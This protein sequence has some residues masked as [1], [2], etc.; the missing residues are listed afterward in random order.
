[1]T[2]DWQRRRSA[3]NHDWLKNR[4]LTAIASFVNILDDLVEDEETERRFVIGILPQWVGRSR[5]AEMLVAD[6]DSAMSPWA[7]FRH[8]P[9]CRCGPATMGW[10]PD[11]V[12]LL[13]RRRVHVDGLCLDAR[14]SI[15]AANAAYE[16]LRN[17][18]AECADC[19][20][21]EALRSYRDRFAA[22]RSKCEEVS[23]AI[24]RFP[25]RILVV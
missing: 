10:L 22:F 18:L 9:L 24:S 16:R 4:F 12:H 1:M 13:W 8:P 5:E 25:S 3:F 15:V 17:G 14:E 20:S 19:S 7:L 2:P 21:A 6:F 11:L 23:R